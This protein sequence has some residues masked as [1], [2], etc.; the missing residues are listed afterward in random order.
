MV[1]SFN[2]IYSCICCFTFGDTGGNCESRVMIPNGLGRAACFEFLEARQRVC[3]SVWLVVKNS[4]FFYR[5]P[6][7]AMESVT[8]VD[9]ILFFRGEVTHTFSP[10]FSDATR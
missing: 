6:N 10:F 3:L 5:V 8:G 2:F 4:V 9:F 7:I 1:C